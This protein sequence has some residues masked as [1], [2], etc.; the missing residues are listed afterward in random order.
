[1]LKERDLPE[2]WPAYAAAS[3]EPPVLPVLVLQVSAKARKNKL[4]TLA[5]YAE[6]FGD[7][8]VRIESSAPGGRSSRRQA[9]GA[10]HGC[11]TREPHMQCPVPMF[12]YIGMAPVLRRE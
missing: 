12:E 7:Q 4:R 8:F 9:T 10:A 6:R 11:E 3:G 1:M 2:R 5:R